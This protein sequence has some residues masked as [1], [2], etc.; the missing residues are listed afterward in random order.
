VRD[1][2]EGM[3]GQGRHYEKSEED[4]DASEVALDLKVLRG[5]FSR[6]GEMPCTSQLLN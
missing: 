5:L 3:N 4:R 2:I 6:G 1:E